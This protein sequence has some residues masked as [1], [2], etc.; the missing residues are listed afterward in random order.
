MLELI[1]TADGSHTIRNADLNETYHSIHGAIQESNHVFIKHGLHFAR[2]NSPGLVRI[3]EVGF[4]TGLNALLTMVES[5][6]RNAQIHY[7]A[8]EA[9][10]LPSELITQLNYCD[11]I[12]GD[13]CKGLFFKM[14]EARW[15]DSVSITPDF[16]ICKVLGNIQKTTLVR[17]RYDI[18]YFDAFAPSRQ[19]EMWSREVLGKVVE[20]I[21]LNGIFVT[22]SS[23]G[24]LRRDLLELGMKVETLTGP[25]G[26][27]E[28]TRAIK[29][30]TSRHSQ[31]N[32]K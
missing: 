31:Y 23:R 29:D 27:A 8:V 26:K 12:Q 19:P 2:Q 3:L 30:K 22:Y 1:K 16:T 20:S 5:K 6:Q 15:G 7:D 11:L 14:H 9:F 24:Q 13:D 18:V 21:K 10:P 32:E 4:G 17:A 28:M 25:P